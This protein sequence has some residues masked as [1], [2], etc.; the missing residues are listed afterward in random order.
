MIFHAVKDGYDVGSICF[1][2]P[3]WLMLEFATK[4]AYVLM[5]S[6]QTYTVEVNST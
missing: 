4:S 5:G 3:E 6:Y 2:H 1:F